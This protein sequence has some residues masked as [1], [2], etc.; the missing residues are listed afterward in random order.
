MYSERRWVFCLLV[1]ECVNR[2]C[3]VWLPGDN[4]HSPPSPAEAKQQLANKNG[5]KAEGGAGGSF[6]TWFMVLALLGVWTS[7]AVVWFDL[8]DYQGVVGKSS[9][10][11]HLNATSPTS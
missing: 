9:G 11:L 10:P 2:I 3:G 6:F 4:G 5:K 7:V 8:V 1:C